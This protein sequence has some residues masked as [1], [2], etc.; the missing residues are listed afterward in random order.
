MC[1][2]PDPNRLLSERVSP[3]HRRPQFLRCVCLVLAHDLDALNLDNNG[4]EFG[5]VGVRWCGVCI[6]CGAAQHAPEHTNSAPLRTFWDLGERE[7]S[8]SCDAGAYIRA[9]GVPLAHKEVSRNSEAVQLDE[10]GRGYGPTVVD[11]VDSE[12]LRYN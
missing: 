5:G 6:L 8:H 10:G 11:P 4:S 1:H 3:R 9:C 2:T 12:V 7:R